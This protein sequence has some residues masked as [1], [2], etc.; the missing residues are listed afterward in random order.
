QSVG[1]SD[2]YSVAPCYMWHDASGG[3]WFVEIGEE[4]HVVAVPAPVL[5]HVETLALEVG[6]PV[7]FAH[8]SVWVLLEENGE[9]PAPGCPRRG[10]CSVT[11]TPCGLWAVH[12]I[13][14]VFAAAVQRDGVSALASLLLGQVFDVDVLTVFGSGAERG[15]ID[16]A[17]SDDVGV[18]LHDVRS[19][20][21][22]GDGP[23]TR[24]AVERAAL[25]AALAEARGLEASVR[26]HAAAQEGGRIIGQVA[27]AAVTVRHVVGLAGGTGWRDGR[28][29]FERARQCRGG[30]RVGDGGQGYRLTHVDSLLLR[31]W[32]SVADQQ[33]P[34]L[35]VA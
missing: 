4:V 25:A 29:Q 20:H 30:R 8:D 32:D 16:R 15:L 17:P 1:D 5:D 3:Y 19:V 14:A 13:A 24:R 6:G 34:G 23:A 2:T 33:M 7:V 21:P 31:L 26:C 35:P 11:A 22:A 10:T 27:V 12:G 9:Q 18:E 28:G